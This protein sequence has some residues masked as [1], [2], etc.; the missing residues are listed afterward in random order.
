V[1]DSQLMKQHAGAERGSNDIDLIAV[2]I[3]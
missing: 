1:N 3:G 2:A